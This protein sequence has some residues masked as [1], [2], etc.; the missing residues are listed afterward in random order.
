MQ[1]FPV[2]H[3]FKNNRNLMRLAQSVQGKSSNGLER[4]SV[5][6]LLGHAQPCRCTGPKLPA[7]FLR[8]ELEHGPQQLRGILFRLSRQ[9][10]HFRDRDAA[11]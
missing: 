2:L 3:Q 6:L 7:Y 9:N 4:R 1:Q 11:L 10:G 5:P 8:I